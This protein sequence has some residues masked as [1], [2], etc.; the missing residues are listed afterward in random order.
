[1]K[2][3]SEAPVTDNPLAT[4]AFRRLQE[5]ARKVATELADARVPHDTYVAHKAHPAVVTT[6]GRLFHRAKTEIVAVPERLTDVGGWRVFTEDLTDELLQDVTGTIRSSRHTTSRR[7][8][9]L[10]CSG[11]LVEVEL[12]EESVWNNIPGSTPNVVP[13]K[14]HSR[15][16]LDYR[17][18]RV[19]DG[20]SVWREGKK[21]FNGM[22]RSEE[23]RHYYEPRP[24]V[25]HCVTLSK[26]LTMLR[27][28]AG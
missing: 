24:S 9:W 8:V 13:T 11:Q 14:V 12:R 25:P 2:D 4:T 5:F 6:A 3:D 15:R 1:V 23:W 27:T 26:Q 17:A 21:K 10:L 18:A 20:R 19:L 28:R 7:E 16:D 22:V